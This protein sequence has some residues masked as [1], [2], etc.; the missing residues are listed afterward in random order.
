[1]SKNLLNKIALR[2]IKLNLAV[3]CKTLHKHVEWK[4]NPTNRACCSGILGSMSWTS[5]RQVTHI[6]HQIKMQSPLRNH[7]KECFSEESVN[8]FHKRKVIRH[9]ETASVCTWRGLNWVTARTPQI[10]RP[11][12]GMG[13]LGKWWITA[14]CKYLRDVIYGWN[15]VVQ[16]Q[17][18]TWCSWGY[19]S[20]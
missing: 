13:C 3:K 19:F 11:S 17:G 12:I 5:P 4:D 9:G 7:L 20:T 8:L 10:E 1:M 14:P 6:K 2:E 15:L 16:I 18:W